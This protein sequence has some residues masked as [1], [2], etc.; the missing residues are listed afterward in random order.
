MNNKYG[1]KYIQLLIWKKS[2][3][4]LNVRESSIHGV[5]QS[6]GK[7][8]YVKCHTG[9]TGNSAESDTSAGDKTAI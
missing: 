1:L 6:K 4:T 2:I 8:K 5:P 7:Q 3:L 9:K